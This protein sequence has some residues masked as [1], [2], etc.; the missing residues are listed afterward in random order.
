MRHF[1]RFGNETAPHQKPFIL[2]NSYPV[3]LRLSGPFGN[4]LLSNSLFDGLGVGILTPT[5]KYVVA[6][7]FW[8]FV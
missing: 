4:I 3:I 6:L 1:G 7:S 2:L 8:R 5:S